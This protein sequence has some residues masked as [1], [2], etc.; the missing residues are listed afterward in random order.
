MSTEHVSDHGS[1]IQVSAVYLWAEYTFQWWYYFVAGKQGPQPS[2]TQGHDAI[3]RGISI[4]VV[5]FVNG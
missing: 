4:S 3:F 2:I 5:K 1:N